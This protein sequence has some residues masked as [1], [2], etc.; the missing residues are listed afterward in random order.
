MEE[1]RGRDRRFSMENRASFYISTVVCSR[2]TL[3]VR[4]LLNI[5]SK[6]FFQPIARA[7]GIRPHLPG[8]SAVASLVTSS[9]VTRAL[10]VTEGAVPAKPSP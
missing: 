6:V 8:C 10:Q 3:R 4:L 9:V 2:V 5:F 7:N 1:H